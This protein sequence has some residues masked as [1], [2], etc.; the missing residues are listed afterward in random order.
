MLLLSLERGGR[1][2]ERPPLQIAP[3]LVLSGR[4]R[5]PLTWVCPERERER[6]RERKGATV[7]LPLHFYGHLRHGKTKI[8]SIARN[9]PIF[10][11]FLRWNFTP[12]SLRAEWRSI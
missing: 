2:S 8:V 9:S 1:G 5:G 7:F 6:K 10:N 12:S 3:L 11:N 4:E